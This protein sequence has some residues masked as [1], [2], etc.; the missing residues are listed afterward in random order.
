ME[1]V[2][3]NT[4]YTNDLLVAQQK[5]MDTLQRQM[6]QKLEQIAGHTSNTADASKKTAKNTG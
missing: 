1:T 3:A 5:M 6:L 2:A 4:K